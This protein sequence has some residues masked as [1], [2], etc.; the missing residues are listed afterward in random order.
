MKTTKAEF[1]IMILS[2]LIILSVMEI[3]GQTIMEILGKHLPHF[4]PVK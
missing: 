3:T 2:A 1:I 4:I